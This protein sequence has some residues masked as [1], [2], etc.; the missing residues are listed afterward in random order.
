MPLQSF[1]TLD[2]LCSPFRF[3]KRDDPRPFAEQQEDDTPSQLFTELAHDHSV[4][5][6]L[7]SAIRDLKR[8]GNKQAWITLAAK[9]AQ[10]HLSP[11]DFDSAYGLAKQITRS[12]NAKE[13]F[14]YNHQFWDIILEKTKRPI[15]REVFRG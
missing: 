4:R 5:D 8:E 7:T 3:I 12:N 6:Q 9:P 11:A 13:H 10:R 1:A 14:E 15:L 2:P